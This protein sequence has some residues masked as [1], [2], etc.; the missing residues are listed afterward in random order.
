MASKYYGD[1]GR[2]KGRPDPMLI[3]TAYAHDCDDGPVLLDGLLKANMAHALM[4]IEEGIIPKDEGQKLLSGLVELTK[5]PASRFEFNPEL[6]DAYNSVDHEL[7]RLI[8]KASGWLHV[9]R[10]RREA[11]NIGYL[12]AIRDRVFILAESLLNLAGNLLSLSEREKETIAP[13]FTYLL[14]AQPTSLGHYLTTFLFPIFRDLERLQGYFSRHNQSP[15]GS[16]S[17]NGSSL[18]M[19]RDAL[20]RYLGFDKPLE[21]SRDG[22]W[23]TDLPMELMAITST[24]LLYT[25][26][27]PRDQRGSRMPSSA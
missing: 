25:S 19:N 27:S 13:D 17:V 21:H 23:Q 11:V 6:G 2:L 24:C 5:R 20:A 1:G 12:I 3:N 14:H 10:P 26:P 15:A 8:G 18:P 4:L 16:G 7:T 22:M 9:G